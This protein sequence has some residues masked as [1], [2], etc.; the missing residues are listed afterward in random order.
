[1]NS[2][3]YLIQIQRSAGEVEIQEGKKLQYFILKD[4][5]E[6]KMLL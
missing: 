3:P 6:G 4:I 5:R 1:M 2:L